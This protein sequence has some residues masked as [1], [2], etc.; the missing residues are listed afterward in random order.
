MAD[1]TPWRPSRGLCCSIEAAANARA[2]AEELARL[3]GRKLGEVLRI[4]EEGAGRPQPRMMALEAGG[5]VIK[6]GEQSA[7]VRLEVVYELR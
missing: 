3:H 7:T 1:E 5:G 6:P 4:A 2:K